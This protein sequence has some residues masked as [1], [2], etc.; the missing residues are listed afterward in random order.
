MTLKFGLQ[1]PYRAS[2]NYLSNSYPA[3]LIRPEFEDKM[4]HHIALL[5][6]QKK[7]KNL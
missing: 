2:K 3:C 1:T 6:E 7:K 5:K 4:Q